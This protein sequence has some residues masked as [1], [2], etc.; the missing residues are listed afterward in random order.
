MSLTAQYGQSSW[1]GSTGWT[2]QGQLRKSA[3]SFSS[4]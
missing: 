2:V 1:N 3:Q 4:S